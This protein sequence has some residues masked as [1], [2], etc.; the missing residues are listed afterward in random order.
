MKLRRFGPSNERVTQGRIYTTCLEYVTEFIFDDNGV[1]MYP[2][3]ASIKHDVSSYWQEVKSISNLDLNN[4]WDEGGVE[5]GAYPHL[6]AAIKSI[7]K[8]TPYSKWVVFI[9][10]SNKY[11]TAFKSYKSF[12]TARGQTIYDDN[13]DEHVIPV[14][15]PNWRNTDPW[16][17]TDPHITCSP[18]TIQP[19]ENTMSKFTTVEQVT[20][21]NGTPAD[22]HTD[23]DIICLIKQQEYAIGELS[24]VKVKSEA[25]TAKK[26]EMRKVLKRLVIVLDKRCVTED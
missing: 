12:H 23:D 14:D 7:D 24:R 3:M 18:K 9:G 19:T 13:D 2:D 10:S 26:A 6:A 16:K 11:F 4:V 8:F 15:S 5:Q 22:K 17:N 1:R 21:I 20:M 25:I